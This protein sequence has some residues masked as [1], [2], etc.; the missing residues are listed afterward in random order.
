MGEIGGFFLFAA[1]LFA[2]WA[3][4]MGAYAGRTGKSGA[5]TSA[6]RATVLHAVFLGGAT[7]ALGALFVNADFTNQFVWQFSD[8][9]MPTVY[10][11]TAIWGG[12]DGSMLLWAF[13]LSF[14][15]A[16]VVLTDRH[17]AP[18]LLAWVIC[19][20]HTTTLFFTSVV[21]Y[22][23]NPFRYIRAPFIPPEGNGLNP[24][25]QNPYM[26]AHPPT[27]YLGFTTFAV[28]F[29]FC[30]GALLAGRITSEWIRLTRRW[31]LIAWGFLTVG[32]TLGGHWAYLELGWGGFWAWDPV[33]NSSFLPWLT[34]T[35]FLHSIM[36]Q[37]RKGM[38]KAWN[39]WLIVLTYGLTVFGTFLTRSG[40]VQSVHA[41]ASTDIGWAFLGYLIATLIGVG[42]L[43]YWRRKELR[44]E[45]ALESFL[46]RESAFLVNNLLFLSIAFAVLWGVMFPV[47]SEAVTGKKQTIGIP[48]FNAVTI[49]LFLAMLVLMGVGPLIAWRRGNIRRIAKTFSVPFFC[50]LGIA[51]LCVWAGAPSFY[52]TLAYSVCYFITHTILGEFYRGY[53]AQRRAGTSTGSATGDAVTMVRRHRTRYGGYIVHLGVVVMVLGITASMAHK[54]EVEFT[55]SPGQTESV[56]RFTFDLKDITT[57]TNSSYSALLAQVELKD[58][59]TGKVLDLLKPEMRRYVRK[60]ESTSEVAIRSS[61]REDVYLVLAGL[62]ESGSRAAFKLFINPLQT[63]LWIGLFVV[64]GGTLITLLP[65]LPSRALTPKKM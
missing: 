2:V 44:S 60:E 39:V 14:M 17:I 62:D 15:G 58:Q 47:L 4:L 48:Y 50:A 41:F 22:L 53:K 8:R 30:V 65:A 29:A 31:T 25:L 57:Q 46:S 45:N 38:L 40:I 34:G 42:I 1:W 20:F 64:V 37:E 35:A 28:P 33:E 19:G 13:L 52:T 6:R 56:G 3:F 21:L 54:L 18:Q 36:V 61:L 27:L 12:M 51:A 63:W 16:V 10:K 5:L 7:A 26:A 49:P 43:H 11:I 24:L 23:T 9:S 55:L 32:I 59:G